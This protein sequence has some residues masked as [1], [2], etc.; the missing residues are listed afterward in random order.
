MDCPCCPENLCLQNPHGHLIFV[1]L[2]G[3]IDP[4]RKEAKEAVTACKGAGIRVV[5]ITGDQK[6]TAQAVVAELGLPLGEAATGLELEKMK[7]DEFQERVEKISVF[8]RV[9]PLHKFNI[10]KV[11]KAKGHMRRYARLS[12]RGFS[13][14]GNRRV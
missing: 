6:L 1:G 10:V 9:V 12:L 8:V 13:A 4:P 14:K 5:M 3:M 11:L 2:V 7:E